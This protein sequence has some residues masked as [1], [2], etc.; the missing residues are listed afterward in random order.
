MF[1]RRSHSVAIA[2]ACALFAHSLAAQ[3]GAFITTLGKDTTAVEQYTRSGSTIIGDLIT[4]AGG[5]IVNH[6]VLTLNPDGTPGTLVVSPRRVDGTVPPTGYS[7]ATATFKPDSFGT[8]ITMRDSSMHRGFTLPAGGGKLFPAVGGG[9]S[10]SMAMYEVLFTYLRATKT[11]S[12]AFTGVG[13]TATRP[14]LP[15][16]AKF[17]GADSARIWIRFGPPTPAGP[18]AQ[19]FGID[20]T[21]RVLGFSGR[22]TTQKIEV[23][24]VPSADIA[25]F[26]A[27]FAA[28]DAAGKGLGPTSASDSVRATIGGARISINYSR[29]HVRGRDVFKNGVL[30]DTIWR[31]GANSATSFTTDRDLVVDGKTVPAGSYT[32]WTHARPDNSAYELIFN[33]LT[34]EW[35]TDYRADRDLVRV[36]L[37]VSKLA[38]PVEA[39]VISV[40]AQGNGGILK[41][42]W[43]TTQLSV[44]FTVK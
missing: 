3:T 7:S 33:T 1:V 30:G 5:T 18:Y 23:K 24:R 27:T 19:Y 31:T 29:P 42:Q 13:A 41:L 28:A 21:G 22:E 17:Y 34:G 15:S 39:F 43:Q 14:G 6:Y 9:I 8:L 36:P 11:D 26:A 40:E 10:P 20:A 38:S 32:L 12:A 16:W 2:L 4:R 44:P 37:A 35:G 25:A